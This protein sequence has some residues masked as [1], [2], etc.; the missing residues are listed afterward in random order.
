ML[1]CFQ[2]F[3]RPVI[4]VFHH[5]DREV[6]E[7]VSIAPFQPDLPV[8]QFR[9]TILE[10]LVGGVR[11]LDAAIGNAGGR[12]DMGRGAV[13]F[14][15]NVENKFVFL[16]VLADHAH[17]DS[18]FDG[19]E[20]GLERQTAVGQDLRCRKV[21]SCLPGI[22]V[23]LHDCLVRIFIQVFLIHAQY[24]HHG[25]HGIKF[26]IRPVLIIYFSH[27][28]YLP[29][30]VIIGKT[31]F[32]ENTSVRLPSRYPQNDFATVSD[33][34][35]IVRFRAFFLV[36]VDKRVER[37][38]DMDNDIIVIEII[39]GDLFFRSE[40]TAVGVGSEI[41]DFEL[42]G[43]CHSFREIIHGD[44]HVNGKR[45]RNIERRFPD[46]GVVRSTAVFD[47][48]LLFR[49]LFQ[50]IR[51]IR[52]M[53]LCFQVFQRPVIHVFHHG[54][55]EVPEIVSIAPFQP[56][57]PVL[58]FRE[59]ILEC[60]VGGVRVLDAAIG[61]AGGRYDMGRGAVAFPGN[62][63]NKFVFLQVLADHAH[64]DSFFDGLEFGLERQT[65]VGQDLRCRKV[66]S[67]LPGILVMLHD[68]LVRIFIQVFLIHAQYIHHGCHGIKFVIRP[69]LIIY[70]SHGSYLPCAVII[71]K[72][73][74]LENTSVRLPSRYPQNDFATVSD[75]RKIVRF[76]AFFLV[77][78]DKR[79]ERSFDMD[80]D[81]I[82][83]EIIYGDL[84]FRSEETAVGVGSEIRDFELI[85][86]CLS[87]GEIIYGDLCVSRKCVR[88]VKGLFLYLD[89]IRITEVFNEI[90]LFH[91]LF[92][93]FIRFFRLL[94]GKGDCKGKSSCKNQTG[95][96][97]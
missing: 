26:V 79:V 94:G 65:A 16:Q 69:V 90:Q 95:K 40:E 60:L 89:T 71:G 41:R 9:E 74:F 10:C 38:F 82:V 68:C 39:Y 81:I 97:N 59:T 12:Y 45:V 47:E 13:A 50:D 80:N 21:L 37:S 8:L 62:V 91:I 3:Q 11:V 23:M 31:V 92:H 34:R 30:A 4:H 64:G 6:P 35:K 56:D 51:D 25:C 2:V 78:V 42:I 72:T 27:G 18:F 7:I 1:L 49:I 75:R 54:D 36:L 57:L 88:N 53:L 85:G 55:R 67:C 61:N 19:L 73:V 66:L 48:I 17:G 96:C 63:E 29:C 43:M 77:L 86:M 93:L 5:G 32:L 52:H 70:F 22:L 20:F 14:P 33:R 58:Q 28:S 83:I 24:I 46:L 44:L 76:R 15:G 84:F 87:L